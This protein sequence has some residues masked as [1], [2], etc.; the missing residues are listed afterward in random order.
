MDID[1]GK[2]YSLTSRDVFFADGLQLGIGVS[3]ASLDSLG[4]G[5]DLM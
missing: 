1:R 3:E 5:C 4:L 2:A